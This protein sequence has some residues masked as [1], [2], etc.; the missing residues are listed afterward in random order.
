MKGEKQSGQMI[1]EKQ[2]GQMISE[3]Q[4]GQA[5]IHHCYTMSLG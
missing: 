2:S 5:Q 3:N 1:S 4:S